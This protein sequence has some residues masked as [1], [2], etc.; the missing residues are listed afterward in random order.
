MTL[1]Q[2]LFIRRYEALA[3]V[4][5]ITSWEAFE[6]LHPF[7]EHQDPDFQI[8]ARISRS[9]YSNMAPEITLGNTPGLV[10]DITNQTRGQGLEGILTNQPI[11]AFKESADLSGIA[12]MITLP[13]LPGSDIPTPIPYTHFAFLRKFGQWAVL[14]TV[15]PWKAFPELSNVA[16]KSCDLLMSSILTSPLHNAG[17]VSFR[18]NTQG[19][20]KG[21]IGQ[22]KGVGLGAIL[23]GDTFGGEPIWSFRKIKGLT[24]VGDF[25]MI[26]L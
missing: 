15:L 3:V 24:G 9:I 26:R 10:N 7:S 2:N 14:I 23:T 19:E 6:F 18:I 21:I 5:T 22:T 1:Q 17:R 8:Q 12:D 20:V 4:M 16:D 25:E 11:F 13:S